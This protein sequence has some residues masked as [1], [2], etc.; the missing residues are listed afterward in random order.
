MLPGNTRLL[1]KLMSYNAPAQRWITVIN[2]LDIDFE[3]MLV[4]IKVADS[5]NLLRNTLSQ[6]IDR[7]NK[8][9]GD[10]YRQ[11]TNY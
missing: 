5:K 8:Y 11:M 6:K 10:L 2:A 3:D 9:A 7:V 1:Y 4:S